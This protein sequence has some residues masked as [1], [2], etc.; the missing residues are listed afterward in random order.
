MKKNLMDLL[1]EKNTIALWGRFS[2]FNMFPFSNGG[3]KKKVLKCSQVPIE[4]KKK[5]KHFMYK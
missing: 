1:Q 5:R 2:Y 4:E 3:K